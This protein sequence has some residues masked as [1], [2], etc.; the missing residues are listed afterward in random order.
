MAVG[1]GVAVH[2]AAA[3]VAALWLVVQLSLTSNSSWRAEF[4]EEIVGDQQTLECLVYHSRCRC[5]ALNYGRCSCTL[6]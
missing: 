5:V 6:R 1:A 4:S 2:A 3:Y